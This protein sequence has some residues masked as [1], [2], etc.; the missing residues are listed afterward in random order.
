MLHALDVLPSNRRRAVR[1]G[2]H[3]ECEVISSAWDEPVSLVAADL[4]SEGMWLHSAYPLDVGAELLLSFVPPRWS[5]GEVVCIARVTRVSLRRRRTDPRRAG[6]GVRFADLPEPVR[7]A[8][9]EALWG[10]PPPLPTGER[11]EEGVD[12]EMVWVDT[13]LTMGEPVDGD[14]GAV[15]VSDAFADLDVSEFEIVSLAPLLTSE[16]KPD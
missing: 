1:R 13:L 12:E 2:V 7:A 9:D 14:D 5:D 10:L 3:V 6:M 8:L 15:E 16:P 11:G 4:S